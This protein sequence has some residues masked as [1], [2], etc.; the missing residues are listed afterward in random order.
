MLMIRPSAASLTHAVEPSGVIA[1]WSRL[2]SMPSL[3]AGP[4]VRCAMSIGVTLASARLTTKAVGPFGAAA[5][6]RGC[7]PPAIGGPAG[8]WGTSIGVTVFATGSVTS[9]V[10]PFGV[11]ATAP[12]EPPPTMG[13][14]TV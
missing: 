13:G 5:V 10:L 1:T 9:A 2:L 12:G 6:D 3:I 11:I 8:A 7:R 14:P 4:A